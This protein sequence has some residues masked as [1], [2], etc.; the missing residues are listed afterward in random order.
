MLSFI[1]RQAKGFAT[2]FACQGNKISSVPI[3]KTPSAAK[4][5]VLT[6]LGRKFITTLFTGFNRRCIFIA[7]LFS[8]FASAKSLP[9]V[10]GIERYL[11]VRACFFHALMVSRLFTKEQAQQQEVPNEGL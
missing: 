11:A 3:M 7:I 6:S 5:F 9:F 1:R 4:P 10:I 8:A 2:S